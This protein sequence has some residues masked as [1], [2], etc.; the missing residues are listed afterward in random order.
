MIY[1]LLI[2]KLWCNNNNKEIPERIVRVNSETNRVY[3]YTLD[4]FYLNYTVMDNYYRID[5]NTVIDFK[6]SSFILFQTTDNDEFLEYIKQYQALQN[7]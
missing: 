6:N 1:D 3:F 4:G 5:N 2:T 7:L